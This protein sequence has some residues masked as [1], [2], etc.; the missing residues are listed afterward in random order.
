MTRG[1]S[2]TAE[3]PTPRQILLKEWKPTE[4]DLTG[5]EVATLQALPAGLTVE[6]SSTPGRY[7]V[8]PSRI[9]GAMSTPELRV[10]IEPKLPIERVLFMLRY[11]RRLPTMDRTSHLDLHRGIT[12]ALSAVYLNSLREA[13]RR[14][15]PLGYR[16][17][18]EALAGIRGRVRF[19]DQARRRFTL[20]V[21][22][23]VTYDDYTADTERNRVL[24]AALRR[25]SRVR[26][27]QTLRSRVGELLAAFEQVTDVD[28]DPRQIPQFTWDRLNRRFRDAT[29]L[30]LMILRATS[31][32]LRAG[33]T[34]FR[35]M[36]FNMDKVFEDFVFTA[37][38]DHLRSRA[39]ASARWRH[40][41]SVVLDEA[42]YMKPEPDLSLW[43]AGRCVFVGDAK[44]KTTSRGEAGDL[45][46]LLAYCSAT[47][48]R[49]G[50][51]V[52]AEREGSPAPHRVRH[53][54]PQLQVESVGISEPTEQVLRRC[55]EIADR[56]LAMAAAAD[57]V[58]AP[59]A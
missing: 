58:A 2:A 55:A 9:V 4:L 59:A 53:G 48:L 30:A 16:R 56:V 47:G 15:L 45:Y 23:E 1:V 12:E 28:Y 41:G 21:P 20:P 3:S 14:G 18:E 46:Q 49:E 42:G 17:T 11:S 7:L 52:Y 10:V 25:L 57:A 39:G 33:N 5:S 32:E 31:P 34:T 27:R 40:G 38:G 54:G 36:F 8:T 6:P 19:D 43:R 22:V 37:V 50:L 26:L 29:E 24:K 13:L 51:L 35:G 44:Y